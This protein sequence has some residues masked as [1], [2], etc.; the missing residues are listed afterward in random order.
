MIIR[1][2]NCPNFFLYFLFHFSAPNHFTDEWLQKLNYDAEINWRLKV[3]YVILVN[4]C[5]YLHKFII[6]RLTWS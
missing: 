1:I 4:V 5:I 3:I 6:V 2:S